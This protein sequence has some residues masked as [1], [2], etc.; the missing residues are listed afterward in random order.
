MSP[1]RLAAATGKTN[2]A[3]DGTTAVKYFEKGGLF[4]IFGAVGAEL[5]KR[6]R[7][8][9]M[10]LDRRFDAFAIPAFELATAFFRVL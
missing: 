7:Q 6:F 9:P 5:A 4:G 8:P 3:N 10:K 1:A 2:A